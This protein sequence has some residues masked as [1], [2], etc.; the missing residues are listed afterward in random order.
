MSKLID[1]TGERFGKL[2][3][4]GI[5]KTKN[6]RIYWLCKCDCGEIISAIG[7]NLKKGWP[8]QCKYCRNKDLTGKKFGK[9]TV[10]ERVIIND[11]VKWKVLCDCGREFII[12]PDSLISGH[13]KSCGCLQKEHAFKLNS[14]NLI[15]KRFGKL[16]ITERS[17]RKD[18]NGN[19]YWFADCDC[20]NKHHEVA[21]KSLKRGVISCG[22]AISRGEEKIAKL[23]SDNNVN[24]IKQYIP[25][26]FK[27]S[28]G[29]KP[30]FDFAILNTDNS[31]SYLIEYQGEQHFNYRG[32]IFTKEKVDLIKR[33]DEEK[34]LYCENNNIKLFYI[35][36]DNYDKL[37][38]N[39][40]YF[41]KLI[42]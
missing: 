18:C 17:N 36:Y 22:C 16:L 19:Y 37:E 2:T 9:L 10:I 7:S 28:T 5:D 15:G 6:N 35:N 11:K 40:V 32:K 14:K 1:L 21:W 42:L 24:F 41:P 31:L 12:R 13:T 38:I 39:D 23:L 20:G 27:L 3:V 29:G 33:R 26:N 25:E 34:R 30:R 8:K 4:I